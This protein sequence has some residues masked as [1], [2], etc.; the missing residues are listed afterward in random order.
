MLELIVEGKEDLKVSPGVSSSL[1]AKGGIL[2]Q[3]GEWYYKFVNE[4]VG[5]VG[6]ITAQIKIIKRFTAT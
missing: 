3:F 5:S 2:V 4:S 1:L 6:S